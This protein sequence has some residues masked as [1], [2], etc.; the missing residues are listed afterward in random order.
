MFE[1][2]VTIGDKHTFKD[3]G[4]ICT[5]IEISDPE[6]KTYYVSIPGRDGDLDLSEALSG[7]IQYGMR[8][9]AMQFIR[10]EQ[11]HE[12][13]HVKSSDIYDFCHG[14]HKKIIL[15]SD[16][17]YYYEGRMIVETSKD[18]KGVEEFTITAEAMPYKCERYGSLERW[19]WNDFSFE[20]G[21]IR[22][23]RNLQVDEALTLMI[24]GRRKKAVP[25]FECSSEMVLTYGGVDYTLPAGKSK[26]LDLQLGE[27][28]HFLAFTGTGTVSV[29]YRGGRL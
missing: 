2:G 1:Y 8:E 10:R 13:W 5:K 26:I 19:V 27:G 17:N 20:D 4:L 29:D 28:E 3:W 16:R 25:V 7:E 6:R 23:Y 11:K 12:R 15:D 18:F 9:I 21:I 22:D 24:P 14:Q